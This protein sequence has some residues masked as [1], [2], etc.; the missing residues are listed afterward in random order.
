LN[1]KL[2]LKNANYSKSPIINGCEGFFCLVSK[3]NL[4]LKEA[5]KIYR[6]KD[7]I[8]KI[9]QSM[10][11]HLN[12]KPLR[13]SSEKSIR[14][15]ILISYLVHLIISLIRLGFA[16]LKQTSPKLIKIS[17]SNLTVTIERLKSGRKRRIFSNFDAINT[18]ICYQNLVKT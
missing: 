13:V 12:L 15:F 7:S 9:F 3:E 4:T 5:L 14:G 2:G 10:K 8:E 6:M 17:L 11:S 16:K 18:L 1:I